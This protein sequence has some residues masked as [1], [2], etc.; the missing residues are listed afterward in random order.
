MVSVLERVM[1]LLVS[2]N[3]NGALG[4]CTEFCPKLDVFA[5]SQ[6]ITYE[7]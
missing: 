1:V 5:G 2:Q 3:F 7:V 6:T 4:R